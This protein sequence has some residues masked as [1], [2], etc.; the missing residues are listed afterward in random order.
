VKT[1][2]DDAAGDLKNPNIDAVCVE[3]PAHSIQRF[4]GEEAPI[5]DQQVI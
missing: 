1:H 2:V 4:L 5:D 3:V